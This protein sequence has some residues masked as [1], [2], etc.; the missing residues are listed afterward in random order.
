MFHGTWSPKTATW[1]VP[2]NY[3]RT[4]IESKTEPLRIICSCIN[5]CFRGRNGLA[6]I[7]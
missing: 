4:E 6:E 2:E 3:N 1:N 7:V 5:V